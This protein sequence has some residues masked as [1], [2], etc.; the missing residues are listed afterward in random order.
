MALRV[1]LN[2]GEQFRIECGILPRFFVLIVTHS[3]DGPAEEISVLAR[4]LRGHIL[5]DLRANDQFGVNV[6]PSVDSLYQVAAPRF[7][8]ID[9]AF[10]RITVSSHARDRKLAPPSIV[11]KGHHRRRLHGFVIF[12]P[13]QKLARD[14]VMAVREYACFHEHLFSDHAF[15]RELPAIDLWRK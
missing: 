13:I 12:P 2:G 14:L 3:A 4:G 1:A 6:L 5:N 15:Y 9:P 10:Y 11:A 7:E 8:T